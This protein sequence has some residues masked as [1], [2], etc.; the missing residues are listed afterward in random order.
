MDDTLFQNTRKHDD[1]FD[2]G[3]KMKVRDNEYDFSRKLSLEPLEKTE[4]FNEAVSQKSAVESTKSILAKKLKKEPVLTIQKSVNYELERPKHKKHIGFSRLYAEVEEKDSDRMV[5][6]RKAMGRYFDYKSIANEKGVSDEQRQWALERCITMLSQLDKACD[7]YTSHR[8]WRIRKRGSQRKQEVIKLK[9]RAEEEMEVTKRRYVRFMNRVNVSHSEESRS[10]IYKKVVKLKAAKGKRTVLDLSQMDLMDNADRDMYTSKHHMAIRSELELKKKNLTPEERKLLEEIHEYAG[11]KAT[12]ALYAYKTESSWMLGSGSKIKDQIKRETVLCKI[13][14]DKLALLKEREDRT[15]DNK[16]IFDFYINHFMK[17]KEGNLQIPQVPQ[18][19]LRVLDMTGKDVKMVNSEVDKDKNTFI[20]NSIKIKDRT[21]D[22]LFSHEPCLADIKQSG[23]GNCFFLSV[24]A[25]YVARSSEGIMN[26]MKDDGTNVTVRFYTQVGKGDNAVMEPVYVKVDKKVAMD[27]VSRTLWV[28]LLCKAYST[29]I[30]N[31]PTDAPADQEKYIQKLHQV[32]RE[33]YTNKTIDFGFI[34]NGGTADKVLPAFTGKIFKEKT[35]ITGSADEMDD[36]LDLFRIMQSAELTDRQQ[37][38]MVENGKVF[39]RDYAVF[40]MKQYSFGG[41]LNKN[42]DVVYIKSAF[43]NLF[44]KTDQRIENMLNQ[45]VTMG[46]E[47]L[48]AGENGWTEAR[49]TIRQILNQR[50]NDPNGYYSYMVSIAFGPDYL[51]EDGQREA[52]EDEQFLKNNFAK[53]ANGTLY[54]G[55]DGFQ[56]QALAAT[57]DEAFEKIKAKI[58]ADQDYSNYKKRVQNLTGMRIEPLHNPTQ[59]ER[60]QAKIGFRK[61]IVS[62]T[63]AFTTQLELIFGSEHNL[64]KEQDVKKKVETFNKLLDTYDF[65]KKSKTKAVANLQS[66]FD[67][68]L[69]AFGEIT[70]LP[71]E[72]LLNH[73]K[74]VMKA[75]YSAIINK[76]DEVARAR[77]AQIF[78]GVYTSAALKTFNEIKEDLASGKPISAGSRSGVGK[79][80]KRGESFDKGTVGHHAYTILG[81]QDVLF[82]GRRLH[83]IKLRNPWAHYTLQ[84]IWNDKKGIME[85]GTVEKDNGGVFFMELNHFTRVFQS[86]YRTGDR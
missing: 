38:E 30:R 40:N 18:N 13:I 79:K 4:L 69:A 46:Q 67:I 23:M 70:G 60:E 85:T 68:L 34:S 28:Q 17:L 16:E 1:L 26:M 61:N 43:K 36:E 41:K 77:H 5:K 76:S 53:I 51:D 50:H 78:S 64:L 3:S 86:L 65:S 37:N 24:V 32:D 58:K 12:A 59:A 39:D 19:Q 10:G 81:T 75:K 80:T 55:I 42:H 84:Y 31:Y 33:H 74:G 73:I 47:A 63:T 2:T 71:R 11:I 29:F 25:D 82:R 22:P 35:K 6:I 54:P 72:E 20:E 44:S 62:M 8:I 21:A 57:Q 83:M 52:L 7:E 66:G 49:N 48:K 45:G 14:T 9:H 15:N 27:S 56:D